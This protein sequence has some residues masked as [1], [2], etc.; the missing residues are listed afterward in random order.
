MI[1]EIWYYDYITHQFGFSVG[2]VYTRGRFQLCAEAM[3]RYPITF[4]GANTEFGHTE[5]GFDKSLYVDA[6]NAYVN[7]FFVQVN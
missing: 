5:I 4:L 6:D 2:T 1:C 7:H 3:N